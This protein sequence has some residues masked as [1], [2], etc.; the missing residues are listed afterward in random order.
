MLVAIMRRRWAGPLAAALLILALAA[1]AA[2]AAPAAKNVIML[3][4]DG[5]GAEQYALARWVKGAP[6]AFDHILTGAI[7]TH[8]ADSVIADSAPAG[9]ALATGT[10]TGNKI[11]GLSPK[12]KGLLPGQPDPGPEALRP[13]ASVLEA[14]RLMGKSTGLVAT[15]TITDATPAD[16]I[17]HVPRRK[18]EPEIAKQMVHA[19]P[20]VIMGGG[21][22][23]FLPKNAGGKRTDGLDLLAL[24]A[25]K[26]Y[27]LPRDRDELARVKKGPV[28][29]LFADDFMAPERDR[30][31]LAPA[32]PSLAQ[33]T[34]KAIEILSQN[35][36]GFFLMV[37]ASLVDWAC[38]NNDPGH[39]VGDLL[40]YDQA[41]QI[42]LDFAKKDGQTLVVAV[43]DH[44]TGG[45]SIGNRSTDNTYTSTKLEALLAP[46]AQMRLSTMA[47]WNAMGDRPNK[48][49]LRA[50]IKKWWGMD[51]S[52]D[53][54]RQ[55]MAIAAAYPKLPQY[56]VGRVL[57]ATRT[58]IGW[59]THGHTGG[60]VPLFAFGPGRPTGLLDEPEVA[61]AVARAMGADLRQL[62][63]R[64][65]AEAATALT[66]ATLAERLTP[67]GWL[68]EAR[69]NGRLAQLEAGGNILRLDGE[70]L[71]LEGVVVRVEDTGKWYLPQKAATLIMAP[72]ARQD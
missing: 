71:I 8:I 34:A 6:L 7:R 12:A 3:I 17:A 27:Q 11:V 23:F 47:I 61:H 59:S 4:P 62:D 42:A 33:M 26:G 66:G 49:A 44:N 15:A 50:L 36:R 48:Q 29:G 55:I 16:F 69:I 37:E 32:Q 39:L 13:R 40:A 19:A 18:L 25:Q 22:H 38:H 57:S 10:R 28:A 60:D 52:D 43:S 51:L 63:Q 53:E 45:M 58:V 2:V 31:H 9:T 56:G 41:V 14:A 70:E 35:E 30:P 5:C 64:L 20:E 72:P 24:L 1:T 54:A 21:R 46:I 68:L 65:F 67:R